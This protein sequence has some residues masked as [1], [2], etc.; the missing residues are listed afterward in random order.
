MKKTLALLLTVGISLV[1]T[2]CVHCASPRPEDP[3]CLVNEHITADQIDPNS[4]GL[5]R[6]G[7]IPSKDFFRPV[8]RAGAQRVTV[9]GSGPTKKAALQNA[10]KVFMEK[11]NCDFIVA[12]KFVYE[13]VT[14][15]QAAFWRW[16]FSGDKDF[17]V[18]L[19]GI[20]ITLESLEHVDADELPKPPAPAAPAAPAEK[21]EQK[22]EH[23]PAMLKLKDIDIT[24]TAKGETADDAAVAFPAP[25][26][27]KGEAK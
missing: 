10:I 4:V 1:I 17:T 9:V 6:P 5:V 13:D 14:H 25:E 15:P 16:F 3:S 24:L 27:C 2:G 19:S 11:N 23:R 12:V 21:V 26:C 20:P 22:C 7:I 18:T 8:F